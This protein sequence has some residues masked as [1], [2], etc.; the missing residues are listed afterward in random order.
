MVCYMK[1]DKKIADGFIYKEVVLNIRHFM[2]QVR[3][4]DKIDLL[5]NCKLQDSLF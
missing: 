5:E 2:R 1:G 4:D 3:A